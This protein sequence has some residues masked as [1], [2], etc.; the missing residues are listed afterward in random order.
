M[1]KGRVT[2]LEKPG[3]RITGTEPATNLFLQDAPAWPVAVKSMVTC[4]VD[5]EQLWSAPETLTV[6]PVD[7]VA[8][9]TLRLTM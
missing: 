7:A 3:V 8:G 9:L 4:S 5:V 2:V 6:L 1:C